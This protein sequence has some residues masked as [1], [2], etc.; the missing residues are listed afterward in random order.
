MG[1]LRGGNGTHRS[2]DIPARDAYLE[3]NHQ[4]TSDELELRDNLQNNL[5]V[6]LKY[7]MKVKKDYGCVPD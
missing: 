5:P 7:V 2:W 4:E 6:I 1:H 3:S